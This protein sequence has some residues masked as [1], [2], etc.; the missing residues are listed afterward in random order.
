MGTVAADDD[1]VLHEE[2]SEEVSEEEQERAEEWV[3][4]QHVA[5][6]AMESD[7]MATLVQAAIE[8]GLSSEE[9]EER[10]AAFP[11]ILSGCARLGGE[12]LWRLGTPGPESPEQGEDE[13][14]R[15]HEAAQGQFV[16][17]AG[18]VH[19]ALV[20]LSRRSRPA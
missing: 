18:C 2:D 12:G 11:L 10:A 20:R 15:Q 4:A 8:S 19:N 3:E 7:T 13:E 6:E 1:E 17:E 14:S 16:L 9:I 5:A